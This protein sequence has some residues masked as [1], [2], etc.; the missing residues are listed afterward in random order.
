[1]NR[2]N[3]E[4]QE[5]EQRKRRDYRTKLQQINEERKV[6]AEKQAEIDRLEKKRM[7]DYIARIQVENR[8][9]EELES[10]KQKDFFA[11]S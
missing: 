3:Q 10:K 6:Q 2:E 9:K 11:A 5:K 4:Q 7:A 8:Q 1:M